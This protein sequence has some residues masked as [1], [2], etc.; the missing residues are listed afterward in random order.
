M[1]DC[2]DRLHTLL[3]DTYFVEQIE[4]LSSTISL[5]LSLYFIPLL[6]CGHEILRVA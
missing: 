3:R 4:N 6:S 5:F 2:T 1:I